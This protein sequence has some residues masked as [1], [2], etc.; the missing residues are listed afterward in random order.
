MGNVAFETVQRIASVKINS[1]PGEREL[2]EAKY[3]QVWDTTEMQEDF[4]VESFAAPFVMVKHKESGDTG[5]MTFQARPRYYF[6][7]QPVRDYAR[8]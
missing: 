8:S 7:F 6:D 3:G 4:T 1:N 2:L 5:S